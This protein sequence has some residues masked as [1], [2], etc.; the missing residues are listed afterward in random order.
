MSAVDDGLARCKLDLNHAI[1]RHYWFGKLNKCD[2]GCTERIYVKG[3][4]ICFNEL[5][6]LLNKKGYSVSKNYKK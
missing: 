1:L 4:P 5:N 3:K 2:C 6:E